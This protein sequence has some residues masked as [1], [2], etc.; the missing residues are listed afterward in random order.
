MAVATHPEVQLSKILDV[1]GGGW[2]RVFQYSAS[3]RG[4]LV[5]DRGSAFSQYQTVTVTQWDSPGPTEI[6]S[7][8]D[9]NDEVSGN[10]QS[11]YCR[12]APS[13]Y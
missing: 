7:S 12:S 5:R 2:V 13:L 10:V 3:A 4:Q 11:C 8:L 1:S 6:S 9:V